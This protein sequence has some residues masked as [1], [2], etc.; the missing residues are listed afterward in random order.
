MVEVEYAPIV[1]SNDKLDELLAPYKGTF[2]SEANF[3]GYRN[4][5]LRMLNIIL[6][7]SGDEPARLEK[8]EIA[9]A[10]H[11]L[12][13]F[14]DR[15]L[16]YL[17]SSSAL[18]RA[19]LFEIGRE[20]WNEE[21]TLIIES[22]HKL[23][24]YQGPYSNLVEPFRKAD[25]V[26]VSFSLLRFGLSKPWLQELHVKLPIDGFYPRTMV[27]LILSYMVRH[28]FAPLPNFKR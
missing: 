3:A 24:A 21:I 20:E 25:W 18:A 6:T 8:L 13:V 22:H 7:L 17:E 19:H 11:D 16:D 28:P 4:H 1:E 27:P 15:T 23:S 9:L 26:D 14:P 10:F 5:C 12:T 2:S